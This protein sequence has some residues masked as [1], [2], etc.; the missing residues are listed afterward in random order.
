VAGT[1]VIALE[2]DSGGLS[3]EVK[4]IL[5]YYRAVVY[6][7][8]TDLCSKATSSIFCGSADER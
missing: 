1:S 6:L 2:A 8:P 3:Q 5:R 4:E 7:L